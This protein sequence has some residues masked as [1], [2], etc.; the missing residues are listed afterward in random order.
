[1]N[2][3]VTRPDELLEGLRSLETGEVMADFPTTVSEIATLPGECQWS[4]KTVE[5]D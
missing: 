3:T 2:A 4:V 5:G 1:M